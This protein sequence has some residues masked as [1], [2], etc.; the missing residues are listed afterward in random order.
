MLIKKILFSLL[1]V[2]FSINV[3]F[4]FPK[5]VIYIYNDLGVSESS[6]EH[7]IYTLKHLIPEDYR[8]NLITSE[9]IKKN[10]WVDEA[11]LLIMPGGADIPYAQKL[12]GDG[13]RIIK[14]YIKNG[15]SYLGICAGAYY[16]SGF[17]EFD[18]NGPLEVVG[19]RELSFFKGK[20]IGPV[21]AE[22][23]YKTNSGVRAPQIKTPLL[24]NKDI[25]IYYNGGP[26]FSDPESYSYV[27]V[28]AR[29]QDPNA[30]NLPA[31]L[32]INYGEGKV[33][34]SGV[35]FEYST[36]IIDKKDIYINKHLPKLLKTENRRNIL[37]KEIFK[38]LNIEA[39]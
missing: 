32:G 33:I 12:N 21:I 18:K 8:I 19:K 27:T 2:L 15:G 5:K 7:T 25:F 1:L 16:G 11:A 3:S 26:Y 28:L 22:Y 36:D 31:I 34:L 24:G 20:A 38:F 4:A 23:D 6:I 10:N 29:Y 17:I 30:P 35:H 13:N 39:N 9:E 14:E 37:A